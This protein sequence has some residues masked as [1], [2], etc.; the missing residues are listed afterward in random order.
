M[1]N[2][3]QVT[4]VARLFFVPTKK[5]EKERNTVYEGET[6]TTAFRFAISHTSI[7]LSST[8]LWHTSVCNFAEE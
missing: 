6:T 3:V 8:K 7:D 2:I 4:L 5:K 1:R